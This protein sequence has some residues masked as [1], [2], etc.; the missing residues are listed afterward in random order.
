M[1]PRLT[2]PEASAFAL[3]RARQALPEALVLTSLEVGFALPDATIALQ[4]ALDLA[5]PRALV[6]SEA[7]VVLQRALSSPTAWALE[8]SA[9]IEIASHE[10]NLALKVVNLVPLNCALTLPEV[11]DLALWNAL[12][13]PEAWDLAL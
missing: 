4:K 10:A 12:A 5:P 7:L 11:G 13:W 2:S 6:S 9:S 3:D 1:E 8:A